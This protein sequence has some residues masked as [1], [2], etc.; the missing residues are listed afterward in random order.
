MAVLTGDRFGQVTGAGDYFGEVA[1]GGRPTTGRPVVVV[2]G[3]PSAIIG[4]FGS[5]GRQWW[6]MVSKSSYGAIYLIVLIV[7]GLLK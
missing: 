1:D 3:R 2:S 7:V 4:G 5:A 6:L